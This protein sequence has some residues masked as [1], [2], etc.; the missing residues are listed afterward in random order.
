MEQL[1]TFVSLANRKNFTRTAEEMNVVQST[2][3]SRVKLL[4]QEVGEKLFRRQTR[5]V[6]IT[7]AGKVF[8]DYAKQTLEMMDEGIKAARIQSKFTS[9]LVIGGMNSLW[10]T[11]LIEQIHE[12]QSA[13][14][15]TAIRLVTGHSADIIEKIRIGLIDIGFV[16]NPPSSSLFNVRTVKKEAILLAG[17][18]D[19]VKK[20]D[21]FTWEELKNFPFIHYNWG[22]AFSEWF[23]MEI[24]N[25][26][27]MRYRVDHT[28]VAL[29]LMQRRK[30]IGFMLESIISDY[31]EKGLLSRIPFI[32]QTDIPIQH[33][34]MVVNKHKEEKTESFQRHIVSLK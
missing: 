14:T 10:E 4:E 7:E 34:Y 13:N 25:H 22:P 27:T 2:V 24:G 19:I 3:T 31:E 1:K 18:P 12:Y 28:G 33:V 11:P 29:R 8:L 23:E 32:S 30:G 16:Y 5:H 26:E 20:F 6:E 21:S 15:N 9:R 17:A